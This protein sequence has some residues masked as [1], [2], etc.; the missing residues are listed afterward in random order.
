MN[1]K[2]KKVVIAICGKAR[3]GKDTVANIIGNIEKSIDNGV[4]IKLAFADVLKKRVIDELCLSGMQYPPNYRDMDV[5]VLDY[6]KNNKLSY[7][8]I[9]MRTRL[10]QAGDR[11]REVDGVSVFTDKVLKW[12][13]DNT[14]N[15]EQYTEGIKTIV[16]IVTDLRRL[17]ETEGLRKYCKNEDV[18][19]KVIRIIRPETKGVSEDT[20]PTETESSKI[21]V[22]KE[23]NNNGN[24][25]ELTRNIES[26]YL[27]IQLDMLIA[28]R[29]RQ[30]KGEQK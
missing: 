14:Y 17:D 23:F 1:M 5:Q 4:V 7:R 22:D 27:A 18:T 29:D 21:A 13:T 26:W 10:Q 20:H 9:D 28:D 25:Q 2:V 16:Y 8:G 19:Y 12:I 3:S 30:K 24:L 6:L 11:Y 15:I